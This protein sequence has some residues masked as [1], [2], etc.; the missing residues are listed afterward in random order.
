MQPTVISPTIQEFDGLRY[1]LCGR[2]FQRKGVRLHR[3]VWEKN[4]GPIPDGYHVHHKNEDRTNNAPSNL[5]LLP[6]PEHLG[7]RHGEASAERGRESIGKANDAA[8]VWHG[9]DEGRRWHSEHYERHLRSKLAEWVDVV[10]HEC[11]AIW[12]TRFANSSY[13]KFCSGA[14][15]A[16]DLRRRRRIERTG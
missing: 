9:T 8:S 10:C 4:N 14:C 3:K 5:E 13:A 6:S 2:Y 1:Y 7:G 16:R 15:K 12:Q 11:G